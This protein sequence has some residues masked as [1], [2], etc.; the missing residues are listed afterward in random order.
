MLIVE[1]NAE[2]RAYL[3]RHLGG[4]YRLEEARDGVEA[5][6]KIRAERPDLVVSDV[7]MPRMDGAALCRILKADDELS[8]LPV[9]LLTARAGETERVKGL[10]LGADDYVEKPFS[11]LELK[12]RIRNLI[13]SRCALRERYRREVVMQPTGVTVSSEDEAFYEQ[14]RAVV[15][16]HMQHSNFD[17]EFFASE[18]QM[19]RSHLTRR[20]KAVTGLTPA[21]FVQ[22]MRLQRAAQ[23]LRQNAGRHVYEVAEAVG[24][25]NAAHFSKLFCERFGTPPSAYP[26]EEA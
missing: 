15:E 16:R 12:A 5:L 10:R 17:V 21:R 4:G 20:L 23:L 9:I 3:R 7:M 6:E 8:D 22:E 2:V 25:G 19:S 26:A 13:A 1:D 18:M 24:Y 11:M 14:A